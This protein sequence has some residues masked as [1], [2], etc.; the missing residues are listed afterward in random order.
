MRAIQQI[1][2]QSAQTGR[3]F[4]LMLA[5]LDHFKAINDQYGHASGDYVLTQAAARMQQVVG[6]AG[7]VARIGG[8]EFMIAVP[9]IS[10]AQALTMASTLCEA[11][12]AVPFRLPDQRVPISV[13]ISV[14]LK[15]SAP[16]YLSQDEAEPVEQLIKSADKALY[17]AKQA[18]RNQVQIRQSAA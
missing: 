13:T 17:A 7:F 6:K 15:M 1:A 4:A 3:G 8:E 9:N 18:G 5:D 10:R 11:I 14:G 12:C 16:A 2:Q